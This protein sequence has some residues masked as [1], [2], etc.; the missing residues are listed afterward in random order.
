MNEIII[1]C[2]SKIN[3]KFFFFLFIRY[4]KFFII[5]KV[6]KP[7]VIFLAT[8]I[9]RLHDGKNE[10]IPN[11]WRFRLAFGSV[12]HYSGTTIMAKFYEISV[13]VRYRYFSVLPLAVRYLRIFQDRSSKDFSVLENCIKN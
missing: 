5:S 13:F 1:S 11:N 10:K 8:E 9:F 6:Q 4:Y 12:R 7:Q 2:N 3:N